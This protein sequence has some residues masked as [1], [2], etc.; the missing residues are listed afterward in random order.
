MN[1]V[2]TDF[3]VVWPLYSDAL[4]SPKFDEK[5][6]LRIR[7]DAVNMIRDMESDPQ[8]AID[9]YA[10]KVAFRGKNYAKDP[11]GTE[12]IVAKLTV[13]ETKNYYKSVLNKGKILIVVV[14]DIDRN[15]LQEN[16]AAMLKKIPAGPGIQK[17]ERS[18]CSCK[19]N[20]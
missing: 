19:S 20:F 14:G 17:Q 2:L 6:F 15:L 4:T 3:D 7:Q 9:K 11:D 16:I 10:K 13:A 18:I 1:C 5:E 12:A 8:N